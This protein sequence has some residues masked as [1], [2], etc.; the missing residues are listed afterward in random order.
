MKYT[1]G[2]W[3]VKELGG[4]AKAYTVYSEES[5]KNHIAEVN[6]LHHFGAHQKLY[7]VESA[8]ET[9]ANANLIASAPELLE[10]LKE[11]VKSEQSHDVAYYQ[12][13]KAAVKNKEWKKSGQVLYMAIDVIAKA[14]VK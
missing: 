12:E 5:D 6:R 3:K 4:N 14:E 11:Y 7:N 10:V 1:K 8:I 9:K 2:K 13:M